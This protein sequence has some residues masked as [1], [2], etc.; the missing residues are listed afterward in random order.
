M[1]NKAYP[2]TRYKANSGEN[3][4]SNLKHIDPDSRVFVL[5]N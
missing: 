4:E 5:S 2:L 1:L 3:K